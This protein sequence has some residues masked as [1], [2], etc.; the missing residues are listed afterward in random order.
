MKVLTTLNQIHDA[1]EVLN[2][3]HKH[4]VRSSIEGRHSHSASV[5]IPNGLTVVVHSDEQFGYAQQL[6]KQF[7]QKNSGAKP[8]RSSK[9]AL[10]RNKL[11]KLFVAVLTLV[12]AIAV[13]WVVHSVVGYGMK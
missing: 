7:D 10:T 6:F 3:L 12:I 4:G 9:D 8:A 1:E 13:V 11:D 5:Y 2:W